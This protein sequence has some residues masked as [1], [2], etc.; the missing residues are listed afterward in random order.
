MPVYRCW[1]AYK[2]EVKKN[3]WWIDSPVYNSYVAFKV[4]GYVNKVTLTAELEFPFVST[5]WGLKTWF[6]D[7]F[8]DYRIGGPTLVGP[9]D[10]TELFRPRRTG[11]GANKYSCQAFWSAPCVP[12]S[13]KVTAWLDIDVTGTIEEIGSSESSGFGFEPL[14]ENMISIMFLMMYMSLLMG[15]MSSFMGVFR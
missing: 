5:F 6:N 11:E 10:V 8:I 3:W 1:L 13:V 12:E 15:L 14:V 7:Q 4:N 2:S 9:Y